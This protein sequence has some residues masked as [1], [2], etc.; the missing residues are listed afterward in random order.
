MLSSFCVS[1][2]VLVQAAVGS[3][4][5]T[6]V[7]LEMVKYQSETIDFLRPKASP[8]KLIRLGGDRDGAYLVPDDLHG[9]DA[10][11]SPGVA[12]RKDFEDELGSVYGVRSHMVDFSSEES[13]FVTPLI[14]GMQTFDKKWLGS[15]SNPET[16]SLEDWVAQ[17]EAIK[18]GDLLLQMDIE[19]AE[20][21]NLLDASLDLLAR[22][23]ILV[24]EFHGVHRHLSSGE[25]DNPLTLVTK[26][27][28]KLF[29]TVHAHP[30][31][32]C[33]THRLPGS[34]IVVPSA[35]EVTF[36]RKDRFT[37]NLGSPRHHV[38]L[39]HP[40]DIRANVASKKPVYLSG[41][42]R[43]GPIGLRS[44]TKILTD[45]I[46]WVHSN[47]RRALVLSIKQLADPAYLY[48]HGLFGR[49]SSKIKLFFGIFR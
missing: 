35:V 25:P 26:K 3:F 36:L 22:F 11:F 6:N 27:L 7:N 5:V 9:I 37:G 42:W 30:N 14:D 1:G 32:C 38:Q 49:R 12:N 45:R 2:S 4:S 20:Y 23:R 44:V 28:E 17:K 34:R 29:I 48:L 46:L 40:L 43:E 13:K 24:V 10:C 31:N 21:E 47:P 39:P 41:N 15:D 33:R 8:F 19:G 18:S 16:V